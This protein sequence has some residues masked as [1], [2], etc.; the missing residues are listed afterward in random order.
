MT[1]HPNPPP[2]WGREFTYVGSGRCDRPRPTYTEFVA[3]SS[4]FDVAML[5]GA[6]LHIGCIPT[7]ALLESSGLFHKLHDRGAEYGITASDV[8]FDYERIATRRDGVVDQLWK[9]VQ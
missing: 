5:G 7:K 8:A 6:C 2:T 3:A 9:G 1:P 4:E